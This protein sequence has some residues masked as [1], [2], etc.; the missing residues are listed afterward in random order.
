[1]NW[2]RIEGNWKQFS[3][4]VKQQW[5]KLTDDDLQV[6]E[7]R[8]VELV[9]KIQERYGIARDEAEKQVDSWMRNMQARLRSAAA[10]ARCGDRFASPPPRR[11]GHALRVTPIFPQSRAPLR[12]I[13]VFSET[14]H[15]DQ[16]RISL[17]PT[18]GWSACL[19]CGSRP[20]ERQHAYDRSRH[21]SD[22]GPARRIPVLAL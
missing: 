1:M 5:G 2:D 20:P 9:G 7:G 17:C 19:A 18:L 13:L 12:S 8:R 14:R 3:G 22:P 15:W 16:S 21:H 4:K 10:V 11:A 6:V